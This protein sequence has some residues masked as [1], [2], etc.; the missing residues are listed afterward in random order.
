MEINFEHWS[1]SISII[2]SLSK[3]LD[4]QWIKRFR[5]IDTIFIIIFITRLLI[6]K[7]KTGYQIII[8]EIWEEFKKN[9]IEPLLKKNLLLSLPFAKQD[10]N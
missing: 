3:T 2:R 1:K 4:K 8:N 6:S 5:K 10:K 9:N 7:S